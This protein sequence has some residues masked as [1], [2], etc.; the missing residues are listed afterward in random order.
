[1]VDAIQVFHHPAA[2]LPTSLA[3][4]LFFTFEATGKLDYAGGG[5][6]EEAFKIK[7]LFALVGCESFA[8]GYVRTHITGFIAW[9]AY[10][11]TFSLGVHSAAI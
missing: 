2:K 9:F 5:T 6:C 4:I 3:Y 10:L 11:R 8:F 7:F 1:V